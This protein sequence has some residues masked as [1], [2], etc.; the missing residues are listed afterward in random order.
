[1]IADFADKETARV[2]AGIRSRKLPPDIQPRALRLL[3]IMDRVTDWSQLREPPGNDL[4][5]LHGDRA[6]QYAIRINRQWR[7]V[8]TPRDGAC[9][10]VEITDYH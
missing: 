6:G 7:I 4:H 10:D 3:R 5:V 2:A 9:A 1:M 8:F